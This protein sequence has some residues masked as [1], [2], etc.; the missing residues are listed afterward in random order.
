M[1]RKGLTTGIS[2]ATSLVLCLTNVTAQPI[3]DLI[4]NCDIE[5]VKAFVE[6]HDI[7]KL[8]YDYTPLCYAIKYKQEPIVELLIRN[9][10][11]VEKACHGKT[12]MMFAAK[13]DAASIINLLIEAGTQI[14]NS[15]EAGQTPLI[16]A[17]KYGH[18]KTAKHLITKGATLTLKDNNGATCL[19]YALKSPSRRLVDFLLDQGL[20]I[21][22]IGDVQEG[23]HVRWLSDDRC[24][25]IYLKHTGS[26]N[27]TT[28]VKEIIDSRNLPSLIG[29]DTEANIHRPNHTTSKSSHIY[30]RASKILAIGDLHGEYDSFTKLLSNTGVIDKQLNWRW[31]KGHIVICGDVF[32]RGPKVTECLWLIYKLQQQAERVGG[33]VHLILGNHEVIHL[34]NM[35]R[36][37]LADKYT[38][39]FYNAGL[40]HAEFF[41]KEYELGRWLRTRPLIVKLGDRLFVHGG[42]PVEFIANELSIE[43]MNAFAR[44]VLNNEDFRVEDADRM[45][46]LTFTC[47]EYRGYFDRGGD[48]FKS[49]EGKMNEILSYYGIE[50]IVVGHT[51]V[52]EVT[53]LK[54]GSVVAIDV[55]FGTGQVR[56]QALLIENDTLYRINADGSKEILM[57]DGEY[58]REQYL[59]NKFTGIP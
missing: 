28:I 21:P 4:K 48:Y 13:Y 52:D 6:A 11:D 51:T 55:P 43:K 40:D 10:A 1:A 8:Y 58:Y 9:G 19:T 24:E 37:D 35:G 34:L 54:A 57:I 42:I 27:K 26:S 14:D 20:K 50:Q 22:N 18:L 33:A 46:R 38:I 12:P 3:G 53:L 56:E 29:L 49:L 23:P 32:D 44:T 7:N 25:I 45:V 41:T 36:G 47:T 59:L 2:V 17:C 15:N 30:D 31:G 16:Y 5:G 39:L